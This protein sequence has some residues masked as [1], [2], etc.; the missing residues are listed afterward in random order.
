M[1]IPPYP[2]I[3]TETV[4]GRAG[5]F[6]D[7]KKGCLSWRSALPAVSANPFSEREFFDISHPIS[8]RPAL[9]LLRI[10]TRALGDD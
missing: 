9:P 7:E 2:P 10:G 5:K 8:T 4:C 3:E 6:A 1:T